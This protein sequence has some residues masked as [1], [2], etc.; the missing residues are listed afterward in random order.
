MSNV[1][2]QL[3]QKH[4]QAYFEAEQALRENHQ[5]IDPDTLGSA[6]V[7]F[8]KLAAGAAVNK[9]EFAM[10]LSEFTAALRHDAQ[11]RTQPKGPAYN[12]IVIRAA[13]RAGIVE[14][15]AED[16]VG[17]MLPWEVTKLAGEIN[18]AV[19]ASF[20]VPGE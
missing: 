16:D 12:G 5:R 8:Y 18:D 6:L 3:K 20:E 10:M 13:I 7:G 17:E 9:T 2:T 4:I 15:L 19:V 14:G 11:T 1:K